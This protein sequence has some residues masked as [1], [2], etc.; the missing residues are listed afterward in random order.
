MDDSWSHLFGL[1]SQTSPKRDPK[2]GSA[3]GQKHQSG[4]E[5]LQRWASAVAEV[6]W[7]R[8]LVWVQRCS[9]QGSNVDMGQCRA[10]GKDVIWCQ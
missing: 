2:E 8:D 6:P 10:L 5:L 9:G 3:S 1:I 7:A 4:P